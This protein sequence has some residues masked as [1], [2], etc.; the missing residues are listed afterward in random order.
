VRHGRLRRREAGGAVGVWNAAYRTE[1]LGAE[2]A[3]K[4]EKDK[5]R[6]DPRGIMNPGMWQDAPFLFRP[7]IYP[8]FMTMAALADR[9]VP[10]QAGPVLPE[11]WQKEMATCVQCGNCMQYCPTRGSGSPRR[12]GAASS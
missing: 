2:K 1:I 6:L 10:T 4:I 7:V 3:A 8:A 12:P 9:V 11:G 5:A